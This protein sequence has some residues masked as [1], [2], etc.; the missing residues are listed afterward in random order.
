MNKGVA[1][2]VLILV[3]VGGG[4]YAYTNLSGNA[5]APEDGET[6]NSEDEGAGAQL[7][8]LLDQLQS[9]QLNDSIFASAQFASLRDETTEVLDEPVGRINPFAPIGRDAGFVPSADLIAGISQ[10]TS[11]SSSSSGSKPVGNPPAT[12]T[13]R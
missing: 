10:G 9:L 12:Q 3:V 6:V 2:I 8:A 4:F 5:P 1:T 7:V 11:A 13:V